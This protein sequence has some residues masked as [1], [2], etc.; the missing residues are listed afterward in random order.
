MAAVI[1]RDI[2]FDIGGDRQQIDHVDTRL[3]D[4]TFK[5]ILLPVWVAAYQY[6]GKTYQFV[7]NGHNGRVQGQR[8]WSVWKLAFALCLGAVA[9]AAIGYGVAQGG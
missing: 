6:R 1:A 7:V 4:V 9:A 8:P 2:R 3:S 5:H